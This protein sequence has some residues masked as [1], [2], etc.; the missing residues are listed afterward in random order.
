MNRN[1]TAISP[2]GFSSIPPI[3]VHVVGKHS[4]FTN[5]A[6]HNNDKMFKVGPWEEAR[7]QSMRLN[8]NVDS[9]HLIIP[10]NGVY[11]VYSQ[12]Y[13]RDE[14]TPTERQN[15][16]VHEFL[17]YTVLDSTG[18]LVHHRNLMKS[19]RTKIGGEENGYYFSSHHSGLF[20]LRK[21]D[22]I[23]MKVF[24]QHEQIKVGR[25]H[26]ETFMGMYRIGELH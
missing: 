26:E 5:K 16:S 10:E 19:G 8:V 7:G 17:H 13:F 20:E 9:H 22:K 12:V 6:L 4:G 1:R 2:T 15:E 11:Y 14:R 3:A 21:N 25:D 18:N 24:L 23:Y